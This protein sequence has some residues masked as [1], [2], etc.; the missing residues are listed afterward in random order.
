MTNRKKP[1]LMYI[2][3]RRALFVSSA[4]GKRLVQPGE[5]ESFSKNNKTA[6]LGA[7]REYWRKSNLQVS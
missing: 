4:K 5:I 2:H 6:E 3:I 1:L 7:R